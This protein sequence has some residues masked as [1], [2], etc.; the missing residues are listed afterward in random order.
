[1]QL[2]NEFFVQVPLERAW[3]TLLDIQTVAGFLP[4]AT[5]DPAG[6][7]GIFRGQM[8]LKVG[9]VTT[10][11]RGT[12]RL[13]SVDREARQVVIE[14]SANEA[15]GHGTAA[16]VIRNM[17]SAENGGTRVTADTDLRVTGRQAQFGRRLMED[18][19]GRTLDQFAQRFESY[20]LADASTAAQPGVG[21]V[22]GA[23]RPGIAHGD[24][25]LDMV[26]VLG[27]ATGVRYA[28]A[29]LALALVV[30]WLAKRA[31]SRPA[32]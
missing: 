5:I 20:L 22:P 8:K 12:A 23:A 14:V 9:P 25:A 18:V 6:E 7:D 1:M 24:E 15:Q 2:H 10:S 27:R 26:A 29:L 11:Y 13:G 30:V 21:G 31:I 3:D 16:A 32:P 4:G 19:A 28:A 17:L